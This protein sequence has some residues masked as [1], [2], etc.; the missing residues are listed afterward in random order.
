M[1]TIKID[2]FEI[3]KLCKKYNL[4]HIIVSDNSVKF[5]K[6]GG[7]YSAKSEEFIAE[8]IE[9]CMLLKHKSNDNKVKFHYQINKKTGKKRKFY[10]WDF[11]IRSI[12]THRKTRRQHDYLF[13]MKILLESVQ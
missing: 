10:D 2:E 11:L 7:D 1:N 3:T 5:S 4:K 6:K 8:I 13:R 9:D 12:H